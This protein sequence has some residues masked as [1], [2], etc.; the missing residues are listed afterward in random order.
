MKTDR[1]LKQMGAIFGIFM[2]F[3]YLGV[4]IYLIFFFDM[5]T[6]DKPVLVILGSTFVLYG[7][8]RAYRSYTKI[9]EAFFTK[10]NGEE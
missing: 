5:T 10:D 2:V 8:Y 7:I 1:M 9:V 6:L 3:F 4:G